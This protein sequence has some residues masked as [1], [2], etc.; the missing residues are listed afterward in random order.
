MVKKFFFLGLAML[1]LNTILIG[2]MHKDIE[3][4]VAQEQH[5][6]I[7]EA[8][9]SQSGMR[10]YWKSGARIYG[11]YGECVVFY[12]PSDYI[13][14]IPQEEPI[15]GY[16]FSFGGYGSIYV[17]RDGE[18]LS[19]GSAYVQNYITDE[20]LS[21]IHVIYASGADTIFSTGIADREAVEPYLSPLTQERLDQI[22][23]IWSQKNNHTHQWDG[24]SGYI[25]MYDDC[26]V[27]FSPGPL[28]TLSG[29][30]VA[31]YI[32]SYGNIFEI[33]VF[34][35]NDRL[36]IRQAYEDGLLTYEQIGMIYT[37]YILEVAE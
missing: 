20:Q 19:L 24:V 5:G 12:T 30:Q 23:A 37:C 25:G 7:R 21:Q 36:D 33:Y 4:D 2:C 29:F 6:Q 13:Y 17:Y 34:T 22:N 15:G 9:Y 3:V 11:T 10:I 27:V 14:V 1:L 16:D 8:M 35:E 26:V 31:D 18:I 28:A 32:F